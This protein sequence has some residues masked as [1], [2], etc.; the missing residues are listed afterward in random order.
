M[1]LDLPK[2]SE[3]FCRESECLEEILVFVACLRI[4]SKQKQNE[5]SITISII[6]FISYTSVKENEKQ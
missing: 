2:K 1:Y 3:N 5:T 4:N 6:N